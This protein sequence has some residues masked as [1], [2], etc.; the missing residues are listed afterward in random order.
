MSRVYLDRN[1]LFT[2]EFKEEYIASAIPEGKIVNVPHTVKETA[3]NY[4]DEH[5]YQMV[6]C[7]QK[8]ITYDKAWKGKN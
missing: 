1:W 4:F 5:E 7:Y 2:E 8:N 3:F 6:S